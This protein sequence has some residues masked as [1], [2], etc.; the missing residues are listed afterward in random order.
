MEACN[1]NESL[2]GPHMLLLVRDDRG[3]DPP[4]PAIRPSPGDLGR[5][6]SRENKVRRRGAVAVRRGE[7]LK[8]A[9][10]VM[11]SD[12]DVVL[13]AVTN[14]GR[15]LEHASHDLRDDKDVVL[16]AV[17][18]DVTALRWAS[19]ALRA[20]HDVFDVAMNQ[21]PTASRHDVAKRPRP[22]VRDHMC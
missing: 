13:A 22:L 3:V 1:L 15:A 10:K 6:P 9:S 11:R 18:S 17:R 16:A 8:Y 12:K 14:C 2:G 7:N 20:D 5:A 4:S 19:V 21:Q